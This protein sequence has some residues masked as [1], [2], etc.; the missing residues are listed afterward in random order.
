M[1]Q[2]VITGMGA[3]TPLGNDVDTFWNALVQG[4]SGI[5][6]VD[7]FDVTRHKSKI[8]G[9][10]RNF[11]PEP[12]F[13]R[14][15]RR[16]DRFCQ[17]ALAATEQA[18]KDANLD[19]N[20]E[21][22][23][24]VGVYIGSG[25]GGIQTLLANHEILLQRGPNRVSP[26][27]VPMMIS[28]M[29]AGQVS[30]HF[31]IKGPCLAP[32]AACA[33][34]NIAI[35]EAYRLL[36]YGRADIVLA[37]GTESIMTELAYAGFSNST[38]LSTRNDE[39]ERASRPFDKNR[40]GFVASEGAGI[41][42]LETLRHARQRAA[43]I[44]AEVIGYG[45]SSDAFH[46]VA[47]EPEGIGA[48]QA[49]KA[50]IEDARIDIKDVDYINAHATSTHLSDL[51][52][53]RAIKRVFGSHAYRLAISANKS[54]VGHTLGAAGGVEAVALAKTLHENVIPPTINLETPDPE[55]DLDYVPSEAREADLEIGL[56]NSFGFGG[57]NAILVFKKW[58]GDV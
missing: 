34:G 48:A 27:M 7:T 38:A 10:V 47:P 50:A 15:I 33:T 43:P 51:S 16:M 42:V 57:H 13:G 37:G 21:N 46:I 54:M 23:E 19:F 25:I 53:T 45:S 32:V 5:S 24:R 44:Y 49:M 41:L 35:G 8:G 40:D 3:I 36:Q 4:K 17:F 14:E 52:E 11:D 30:I 9:V 28:N 1:E 29:A 6:R 56:S 31:G 18:V 26:T 2:V 58:H 22:H 39:P 55:C 20:V 12:M